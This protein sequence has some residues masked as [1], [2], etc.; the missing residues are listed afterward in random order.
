MNILKRSSF[1]QNN[2]LNFYNNIKTRD[3]FRKRESI[4][5]YDDISTNKQKSMEFSTKQNVNMSRSESF[6][7][8]K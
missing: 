3:I 5:K 1:Q 8:N 4:K 2:S 7:D 6:L